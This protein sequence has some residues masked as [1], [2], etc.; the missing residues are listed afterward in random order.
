VKKNVKQRSATQT[1]K[2]QRLHAAVRAHRIC[3]RN[4]SVVADVIDAL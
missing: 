3:D 1:H 2:E 4:G